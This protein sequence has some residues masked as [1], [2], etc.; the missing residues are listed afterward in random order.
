MIRLLQLR[1]LFEEEAPRLV[2][3]VTVGL[4]NTAFGYSVFALIELTSASTGAAIVG[5]NVI[6]MLFNYLTYG[7]LIF[8]D[9][10]FRTLLPFAAG[11]AVI[12]LANFLIVAA[13]IRL[14]VA[15]LPAQA[16]AMPWL[17]LLS[18]LINR[19]V[20]FRAREPEQSG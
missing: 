10:G 20:V 9:R 15:A 19:L 8:S 12:L 3:F 7:R 14:C 13:L 18:Y 4:L 1:A 16:I 11:Y 5:A 2:K 6:G 17:I